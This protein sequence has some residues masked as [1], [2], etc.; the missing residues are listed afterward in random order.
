[1]SG[2]CPGT[3]PGKG[4]DCVYFVSGDFV[5]LYTLGIIITIASQLTID[6]VFELTTV[7]TIVLVIVLA[8]ELSIEL[9]IALTIVLTHVFAFVNWPLC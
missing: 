4:S 8:S 3:V 6:L 7:L 1:M 9:T 5:G 2:D